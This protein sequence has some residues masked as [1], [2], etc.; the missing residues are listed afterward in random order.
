MEKN[1]EKQPENEQS[2]Y[3]I[4]DA[5]GM[6][7]LVNRR[8][9]LASLGM[10]GAALAAGSLLNVPKAHALSPVS[11]DDVEYQFSPSDPVRSLTVKLREYASV[12]DFGAAGDGVT[13]DTTAIQTAVNSAKYVTVPPGTYRISSQIVLSQSGFSLVSQ[14]GAKFVASAAMNSLIYSQ[15]N[16]NIVIEGG[17]FDGNGLSVSN[18]HFRTYA[19]SPLNLT[20]RNTK[21]RATASDPNL[22][23][24]CILFDNDD[25]KRSPYRHQNIV[26]EGNLIE[27]C[28]THGALAAY[29]D[30]VTFHRNV[31]D[32]AQNHGFEAV[33]CTD[34]LETSNR[35]SNCGISA[36]GVG[37]GSRNYIIAD[38]VIANCGGDG[39]IT[40]EHNSVFG[41]V[42]DNTIV[43]AHGS[44]GINVSFGTPGS[45]PFD[46]LNNISVTNNTI[47]GKNGFSIVGILVYS[48]VGGTSKGRNMNVVNNKLEHV[49]VAVDYNYCDSST[50]SGNT[51]RSPVGSNSKLINI[52]A[53]SG[54]LVSGNRTYDLVNDHA[55]TVNDYATFVSDFCKITD[56]YVLS[57]GSSASKAV[58]Y[59]QGTGMHE[60]SG[61]M[62][63]GSANYVKAPN[64]AFV[65]AS[66]NFGPLS[67]TPLDGPNITGSANANSTNDTLIL[68]GKRQSY[69]AAAPTSG[70]WSPGEIVWSTAPTAGGHAGWICTTA[71]SPG[72]WK[73][74][75]AVTP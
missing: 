5:P 72:T 53:C 60:V 44:S 24:G 37:D 54:V 11:S 39:S 48:S 75:G 23:F 73:T 63:Q 69:G 71:G 62:T 13:D 49:T 33:N 26:I 7:K 22:A 28:G 29:C 17:Q 58:V 57:A 42:C 74:F 14:E 10:A 21:Q 6:K 1:V 40:C 9:M 27:E 32:G 8:T 30:G 50:I 41:T 66:N 25:G 19:V 70:T 67:G 43:D 46:N 18:I 31:V 12:M 61:N 35:V 38:N 65:L 20:V 34:V 4:P 45:A 2:I 3:S 68:N 51:L 15:D 36:L 59:I 55:I 52:V 56:N 64:A 16:S 47:S